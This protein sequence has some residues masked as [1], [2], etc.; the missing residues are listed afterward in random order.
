STSTASKFRPGFSGRGLAKT[1][2]LLA[3]LAFYCVAQAQTDKQL[4]PLPTDAPMV[5]FRDKLAKL[6]FKIA[7]ETYTNN[8]WEIF[9]MNADGSEPV[10][11]TNTST[12]HEHYPQVSPDGSKICF[13]EDE[14]QGRE[15]VRSLYVMD[16][17][18]RNRKKLVDHAREP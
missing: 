11:L 3:L 4:P 17:D 9:V 6:P 15:T 12:E 7:Y 10:N 5:P 8:N 16:I 13:V 18:G 1:V 14:G 2:N